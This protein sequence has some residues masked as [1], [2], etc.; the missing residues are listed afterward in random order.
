MEEN[1]NSKEKSNKPGVW[2][3]LIGLFLIVRGIMRMADK[4]MEIFGFIMILVGAG[5][6][7]YY[8]AKK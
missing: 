7:V 3:L 4:E 6:I 8:F 1:A 2:T 5:S